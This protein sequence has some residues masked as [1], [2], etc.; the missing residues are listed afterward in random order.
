M[1]VM[2]RVFSFLVILNISVVAYCAVETE[3]YGKLGM[4]WGRLSVSKTVGRSSEL[5]LRRQLSPK[6]NNALTEYGSQRFQKCYNL[7][8]NFADKFEDTDLTNEDLDV[9][10]ENDCTSEILGVFTAVA[11]YC[12]NAGSAVSS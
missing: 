6:C 8:D 11:T 5:R 1:S 3:S 9:Y 7:F 10:C 4:W 12:D 2:R